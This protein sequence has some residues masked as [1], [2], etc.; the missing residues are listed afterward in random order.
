MCNAKIIMSVLLITTKIIIFLNANANLREKIFLL[1]LITGNRPKN[2]HLD[3]PKYINTYNEN[4]KKLQLVCAKNIYRKGA[5][6]KKTLHP[7][8]AN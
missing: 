3:I 1:D 6:I 4:M 5:S 7:F 8:K 2:R